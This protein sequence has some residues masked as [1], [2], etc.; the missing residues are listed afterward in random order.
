MAYENI[1]LE[2]SEGV[3]VITLNRPQ[4]LNA[5]CVALV[6]GAWVGGDDRAIHFP[7]ILWGQGARM[8]MP[9]W[10]NY[11]EKVYQDTTLN[12]TK[13]P[14]QKPRRPLSIQLDCFQY[15]LVDEID[16]LM[17]KKLDSIQQI[18]ESDIF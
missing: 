2:T 13:G 18:D 4:A 1:L 16:S 7:S 10:A 17:L 6:A 11:M 15:G 5:L 9:I 12:Y 14:F 8:A 3:G